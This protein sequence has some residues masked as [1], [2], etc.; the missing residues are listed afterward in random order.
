MEPITSTKN[1]YLEL[2][3]TVIDPEFGHKRRGGGGPIEEYPC[4]HAA[5]IF[6]TAGIITEIQFCRGRSR[7]ELMKK[8]NYL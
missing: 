8:N 2:N 6:N 7:S 5:Y 3:W 4:F 1:F